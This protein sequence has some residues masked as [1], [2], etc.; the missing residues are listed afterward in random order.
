MWIAPAFTGAMTATVTVP[1]TFFGLI[2]PPTP[3]GQNPIFNPLTGGGFATLSLSWVAPSEGWLLSN[4]R[5]ELFAE[6]PVPEPA[7]LLLTGTG[8]AALWGR[9]RRRSA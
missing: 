5:Y 8:L 1:I 9:R 3:E 2:R 4:A 7:T 6:E